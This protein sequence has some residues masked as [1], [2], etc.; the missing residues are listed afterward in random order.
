MY[1]IAGRP[2]DVELGDCLSVDEPVS[3]TDDDKDEGRWRDEASLRYLYAPLPAKVCQRQV[4]LIESGDKT[5]VQAIDECNHAV[6][7]PT[8]YCCRLVTCLRV[9]YGNGAY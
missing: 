7:Q 9:S 5:K 1:N 8:L 2:N 4:G 6:L 3:T